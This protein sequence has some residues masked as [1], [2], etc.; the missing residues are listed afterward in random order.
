MAHE[1]NPF[2]GE[3]QEQFCWREPGRPCGVDCVAY[4][5]RCETDPLWNPCLL[6]NLKRAKA[7]SLANISMELK[8]QNDFYEKEGEEQRK[9]MEKRVQADAYAQKVREMDPG[10]PEIK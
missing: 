5:D 7:K 4:D 3:E 2:V 8:R 6:L 9:R 1:D 10:P